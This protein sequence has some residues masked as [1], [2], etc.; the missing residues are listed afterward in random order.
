[1]R[2]NRLYYIE[3]TKNL[4]KL[5]LKKITEKL[6]LKASTIRSWKKEEKWA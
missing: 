3:Q 6:S 4:H 5:V 2:V 1:M